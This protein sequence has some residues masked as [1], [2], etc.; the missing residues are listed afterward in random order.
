MA[1]SFLG[2]GFAGFADLIS[3]YIFAN[4]FI[5]INSCA[6]VF[7]IIERLLFLQSIKMVFGAGLNILLNLIFIPLYGVY[8]AA[9]STLISYFIAIFVANL[10]IKDLKILYKMQLE[11][12]K[13]IFSF[14][15]IIKLFKDIKK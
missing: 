14:G 4:L 1:E 8:G 15:S 5:F 3:L 9:Y 13:K 11:G 7:M 6:S 12:A 2:S 10:F